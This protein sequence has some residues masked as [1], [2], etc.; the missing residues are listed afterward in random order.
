VH[1]LGR[2]VARSEWCLFEHEHTIYLDAAAAASLVQ[3]HGFEVLSINPLPENAVRANSLI[4]V[5]RR[6]EER[7]DFVPAP[8]SHQ[9]LE[10]AIAATIDR[11]DSWLSSIPADERV[12][13]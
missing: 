6:T 10:T 9:T 4:V 7:S 5:A 13:G 8:S 1:D 3:A 2:I 11:I 12:V